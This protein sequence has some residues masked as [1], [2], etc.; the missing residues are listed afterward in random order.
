[1]SSSRH[2]IKPATDE[3]LKAEIKADVA[4]SRKAQQELMSAGQYGMA[5][6]MGEDADEA[7]DELNA[8]NNGTWKPRH[9]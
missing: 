4:A 1:M 9:V 2:F 5:A 7:L 3:Q 6:R 8:V